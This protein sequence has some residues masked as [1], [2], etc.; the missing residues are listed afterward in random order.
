VIGNMGSEMRFNYTM[1]GDSVN[2]AARCES[3]AK[4][5]GVY[6]MVTSD[7]LEAAL[8]KGEVLN[9]RKLDRIVV[10]GRSAPVEVYEL[11]DCLHDEAETHACRE[12]YES[13][14]AHYFQGEWEA[15]LAGF[16]ASARVEPSREFAPTTPSQVLGAR[17][18]E[19]IANGTPV[20][21][22]GTYR[23]ESK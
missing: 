23:M 18:R 19:F 4:T 5:Y 12:K 10:K 13:A 8:N 17:C 22:D 6:I 16:E 21:W 20:G 14:L 9:Y 11:W 7:A 1:M 2:L 15:A 3:G